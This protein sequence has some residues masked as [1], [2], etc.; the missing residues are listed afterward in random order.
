M[1][2]PAT[3]EGGWG[4][5]GP[6][7]RS[8]PPPSRLWQQSYGCGGRSVGASAA[9][10]MT[11][12]ANHSRSEAEAA[13]AG[14]PGQRQAPRAPRLK[15]ARAPPQ[16]L[17]TVK[18]RQ[19]VGNLWLR[20]GPRCQR[21]PGLED[22][23]AQAAPTAAAA[24][25]RAIAIGLPLA[26]G[27]V[28][29]R[30]VARPGA[31]RYLLLF[32]RVASLATALWIGLDASDTPLL[33]AAA[34]A[35]RIP[36]GPVT[37]RA[38]HGRAVHFWAG[39]G[40]DEVGLAT[41]AAI[42]TLDK[43]AAGALPLTELAVAPVAPL[44][45][46]AIH[47]RPRKALGRRRAREGLPQRP[48]ARP[49]AAS[50]VALHFAEAQLQ[51]SACVR[52]VAPR[53]PVTKTAVPGRRAGSVPAARVLDGAA[54]RRPAAAASLPRHLALPPSHTS[55]AAHGALRPG[56]PV[57]PLGVNAAVRAGLGVARHDLLF[58]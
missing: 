8:P 17:E 30:L 26:P 2:S 5:G 58:V 49:A 39:C 46:V 28:E 23:A 38:I 22:E 25:R 34:P 27:A 32:P 43:D 4:N 57:A 10:R 29:G 35:A 19:H 7:A 40:F 48:R 56:A 20:W 21:R 37:P 42:R 1:A 50:C 13:D 12:G 33:A 47:R 15:A 9:G 54:L 36:V 14:G 52:A 51:A 31:V 24:R 41:L 3:T 44:P 45:E 53:R 11:A 16:L 18:Q 55:A 6:W